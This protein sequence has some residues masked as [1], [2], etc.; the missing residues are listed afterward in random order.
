MSDISLFALNGS[1]AFAA[2]VARRLGVSLSPLEERDFEDGEHKSRPLAG[3]RGHD[4]YVLHSLYG[5][6]GHSVNDKLVRLLFAIGALA[7][8]SAERVTAVLPYLCYARKEQQTQPR[9]PVLT[10][11]VAR[12]FEAAG[13]FRILAMDVHN[14]A[15]FQNAYRCRTDHLEAAPLFVRHFAARFAGRRDG[16]PPPAVVSPD[17][18]GVKRAERFRVRLGRALGEELPLAFLEKHRGGGLLR[19]GALV[20]EVAGRPAV[21]VDDLIAT[22]STLLRAAQACRERGA[23]AVY[24]AASHGIFC[25]DAEKILADPAI[26]A[27]AITDS[28]PPFRLSPDLVQAKVAV[29]GAAP[30]FADAIAA[31]HGGGSLTALLEGG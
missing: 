9:D 3:V 11:Y 17:A 15:A 8:A 13:A 2:A 16:A 4:V 28:I 18:G 31:I 12:L 22:G 10:R 21:V 19:S 6:P 29:L 24:A 26:D 20:G 27:V 25:G 7:D 1:C 5:E 23:T 14:L 30:L